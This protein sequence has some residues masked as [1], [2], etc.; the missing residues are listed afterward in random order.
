MA[1]KN[2]VQVEAME[3]VEAILTQNMNRL[4]IGA[5]VID[6]VPDEIW[7]IDLGQEFTL[8][9]ENNSFDIEWLK[10]NAPWNKRLNETNQQYALFKNYCESSDGKWN[11]ESTYLE[12][13]RKFELVDDNS[14]RVLWGKL[15]EDYE[16]LKRRAAFFRY[17]RWIDDKKQEIEHLNKIADMRNSQ[18]NILHGASVAT[19]KL[20]EKLTKRIDNLDE[21]EIA[22][23]DIPKYITALNS[24]LGIAA[25]AEARVLSIAGLLEVLEDQIDRKIFQDNLFFIGKVQPKAE[26]NING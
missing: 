7:S 12:Y 3:E 23:R 9:L 18:A 19:I 17:L 16:W 2:N 22:A 20:L 24:F 21:T 8:Q 14:N 25:D 4:F 6:E 11:P 10:A 13:I 15:F 26:E 5:D 1:K